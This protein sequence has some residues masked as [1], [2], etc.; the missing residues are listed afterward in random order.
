MLALQQVLIHVHHSFTLEY[1]QGSVCL[2]GIAHMAA[3][4]RWVQCTPALGAVPTGPKH[5]VTWI[6][7]YHTPH[8]CTACF[9]F[10]RFAPCAAT[11]SGPCVTAKYG[12]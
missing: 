10:P 4:L 12:I 5:T 1:M 3:P 7:L 2:P 9:I 11:L 6:T 8:H